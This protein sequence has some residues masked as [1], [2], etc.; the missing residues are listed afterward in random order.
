M[1]SK[2]LDYDLEIISQAKNLIDQCRT[3]CQSQTRIKSSTDLNED[4]KLTRN[5]ESPTLEERDLSDIDS[6]I[7]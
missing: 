1:V 4:L 5:N 3:Q 6:I 7:N 2:V